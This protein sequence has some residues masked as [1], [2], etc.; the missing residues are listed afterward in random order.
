MVYV[1]YDQAYTQGFEDMLRR[2]PDVSKLYR[3]IGCVPQTSL[4]GTLQEVIDW[5][6]A[7]NEES[8]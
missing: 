6:R 1:P 4:D 8:D 5:I 7:E 3:Y 2:M